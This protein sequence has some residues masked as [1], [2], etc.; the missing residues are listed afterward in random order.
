MSN[1]KQPAVS[2]RHAGIMVAE[3]GVGAAGAGVAKQFPLYTQL[4]LAMQAE[5]V[6]SEEQ[7]SEQP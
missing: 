1:Q 4:A 6:I 5:A 3:H 7:E 2:A